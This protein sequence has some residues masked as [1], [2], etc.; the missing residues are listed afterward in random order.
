M[1]RS[2]NFTYVVEATLTTGEEFKSF[3]KDINDAM[4]M[5]GQMAKQGNTLHKITVIIETVEE[6][7]VFDF[8][9][10]REERGQ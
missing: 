6:E 5:A 10:W 4:A 1:V 8:D 2:K 9:E 7:V 3:E